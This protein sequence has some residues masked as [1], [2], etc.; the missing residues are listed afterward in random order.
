MNY[1]PKA[2]SPTINWGIYNEPHA[3]GDFLK[4][5]CHFQK[6]MKVKPCGVF[7]CEQ[8]PFVAASPDAIVIYDCCGSR[9]LEVKNPYKHQDMTI[10]NCAEQKDSCLQVLDIGTVSLKY[11]HTYYA[12]FSFRYLPLE[13]R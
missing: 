8:Y 4:A 1:Y 3:I 13:Q 9:P 6:R 11:E 12:K 5:Q 10:K 2:Y 7:I